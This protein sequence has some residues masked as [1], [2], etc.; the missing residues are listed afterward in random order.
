M[1]QYKATKHFAKQYAKLAPRFQKKVDTAI[2]LFKVNEHD[3]K[4]NNH[5]LK[6]EF[7]GIRSIDA[8]FDLRILYKQ[9]DNGL[10]TI[11]FISLGSHSQLYE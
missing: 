1:K 2:E 7:K 6:G 10:I 8:A 3:P 9:E 4:L 11:I 5:E